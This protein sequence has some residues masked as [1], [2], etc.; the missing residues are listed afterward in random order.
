MG[1]VRYKKGPQPSKFKEFNGTKTE[2]KEIKPT[3][4]PTPKKKK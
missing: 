1:K 2:V 3:P 4:K